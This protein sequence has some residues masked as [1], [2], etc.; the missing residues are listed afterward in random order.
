MSRFPIWPASTAIFPNRISCCIASITFRSNRA[1]RTGA[2][3]AAWS[4]LVSDQLIPF[5]GEKGLQQAQLRA[6]PF[7]L[8]QSSDQ[9]IWIRYFVP[10]DAAR[11]QYKGVVTLTSDHGEATAPIVLNVWNFELPVRP[12]LLSAFT[13]YNQT[14][15]DPKIFYAD[16][17]ENQEASACPR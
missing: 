17:K 7:D 14:S 2:A 12:S 13:L 4:R 5:T 8:S 9:P 11:G 3:V 10:R 16:R 1:L 15:S 6:A